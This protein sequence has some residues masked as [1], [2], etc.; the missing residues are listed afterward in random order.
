MVRHLALTCGMAA[1]FAIGFVAILRVLGGGSDAALD[2]ASLDRA[3][4]ASS[5]VH[6]AVRRVAAS[7]QYKKTMVAT[8]DSAP[9][10][11]TRMSQRPRRR[12]VEQ[13]HLQ[14]VAFEASPFPY[15]GRVPATNAPFLNYEDDGRR[16]RKTRS[17][18]VY[19]EDETYNDRR[20]LLHIPK[21]FDA[22]KPAV[23]V[24]FFH[25]MGATLER[26]VVARQQVPDQI[27]ASGVNAI[28][29]APQFAV[30]ARDSSAGSFWKPGGVKRFLG[31]VADKLAQLHGDPQ[32]KQAFATMPVVIVG[33]SGGYVPTAS[34]LASGALDKRLQGTVLLDGLYGEVDKFADWIASHRSGFFVSA[35]TG[36]TKR[37][38]NALKSRLKRKKIPYRTQ[39]ALN[40]TLA[41]G[42]VTFIPA[43]E[44]HR[45]YVTRAWTDNPI[46]DV[47]A[48][49]ESIAPRVHK[50]HSASL[51]APPGA[52]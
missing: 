35:H 17:G 42:S 4:H 37:G 1:A 18:R 14:L 27:L 38:N 39:E 21:G 16:G 8:L 52:R 43:D 22:N 44:K 51:L 20:V 41:P 12:A 29:V 47:L 13:T 25:G 34:A 40:G 46:S 31:E 3:A 33:Y 6:Y 19:W 5:S 15:S 49:M 45:H 48:R 26:D 32:S 7:V 2:M 11:R 36:S 9:T 24:L 30:N 23:M 50:V 10:A 28:L